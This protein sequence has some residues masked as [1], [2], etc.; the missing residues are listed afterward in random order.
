MN[1]ISLFAVIA[2]ALGLTAVA[3]ATVILP[4]GT[5]ALR[6]EGLAAF[7]TSAEPQINVNT[8]ELVPPAEGSPPLTLTAFGQVNSILDMTNSLNKGTINGQLTFTYTGA[9]LTPISVAVSGGGASDTSITYTI[10]SN[11]SGGTIT[12]YDNNSATLNT[13]GFVG[14]TFTSIPSEATAGTVFLTANTP[15]DAQSSITISFLRP[16]PTS[17]YQSFESKLQQLNGST[18]TITGGSAL[19]QNPLLAGKS[20]QAS[21]DGVFASGFDTTTV[22]DVTVNAPTNKL[23]EGDFVMDTNVIPEPASV[24]LLA[25]GGVI[26]LSGRRQWR[27]AA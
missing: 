20:L 14:Q 27:L 12:L 24:C 2:L 15:S 17:A 7:T 9:T 11:V 25:L 21:Q 16:T 19:T 22:G 4:S 10:T 26:L 23:M 1:K 8:G 18:F 6:F 13:A 5:N 3:Q